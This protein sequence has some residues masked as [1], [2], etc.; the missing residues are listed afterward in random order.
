MLTRLLLAILAAAALTVAPA[1]IEGRY[2]NRW[3][4][5]RDLTL[6][7]SRLKDFPKTIGSW[8]FIGDS[9][10]L[11][12]EVCQELRLSGYFNRRY[13]DQ[14]SGDVVQLL[15]ML[16][17]PGALLR[18]EPDVCYVRRGHKQEGQPAQLT[19]GDTTANKFRTL[20][21]SSGVPGAGRFTVSYGLKTDE[22]SW[23]VPYWRRLEFAGAPRLF[24]I[25]VLSEDLR[26]ADTSTK[27]N[28]LFLTEFVTAFDTWISQEQS[29][30]Q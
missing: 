4:A 22:T 15:L 24:K 18:H 20:R 11:P 26:G 1:L 10:Q 27:T 16:G 6:A 25:Q 19:V 12:D 9:D 23:D 13:R 30:G 17:Q 14:Q 7:A 29:E 8:Q 3:R 2:V 21:Y 5:P 28:E